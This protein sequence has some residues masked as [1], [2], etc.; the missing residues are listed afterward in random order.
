[1]YLFCVCVCVA[2]FPQYSPVFLFVY[3]KNKDG[4]SEKK[5]KEEYTVSNR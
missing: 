4:I 2:S 1:M 5:K 3:C